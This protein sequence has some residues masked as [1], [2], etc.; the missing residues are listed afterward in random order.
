M[1]PKYQMVLQW[2]PESIG[3]YD[4]LVAI[5]NLLI[6]NLS[7]D[8]QIDGHDST[9]DEMNIFIYAR[10]P[11]KA[12]EEVKTILGRHECWKDLRAAFRKVKAEPFTPLWPPGSG[13]F[14]VG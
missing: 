12:F 10:H 8:Y 7:P 4:A 5:E 6:K 11:Q 9:P 2:S 14:K 13:E 1:L 3:D